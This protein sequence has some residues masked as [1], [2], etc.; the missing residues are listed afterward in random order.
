MTDVTITLLNGD[1]E[2]VR[3]G[4]YTEIV[5]IIIEISKRHQWPVDFMSRVVLFQEEREVHDVNSIDLHV[6]VPTLQLLRVSVSRNRMHDEYHRFYHS[7]F[8]FDI[9]VTNYEE[10]CLLCDYRFYGNN[11]TMDV[12]AKVARTCERE[13]SSHDLNGKPLNCCNEDFCLVRVDVDE[14]FGVDFFEL[15]V[16]PASYPCVINC[17]HR[18]LLED[19]LFLTSKQKS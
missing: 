7:D 5:D 15:F 18:S 2:V 12:Y 10:R 13:W 6:P 19:A 4:P 14:L 1:T 16:D 17:H 3:V 8:I 9:S 11:T